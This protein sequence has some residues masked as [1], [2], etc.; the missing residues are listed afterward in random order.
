MSSEISSP[1]AAPL[2]SFRALLGGALRIYRTHFVALMG[3]A[4]WLALP[5][6]LHVV[7]RITF[8]DNDATDTALLVVSGAG[9]AIGTWS[10]CSI[11]R[12]AAH[13]HTTGHAP[14]QVPDVR[15]EL[16]PTFL[17]FAI[18]MLVVLVGFVAIL[19][20]IL[21]AVWF[22]FAPLITTLEKRNVFVALGESRML[23]R[24]RFFRILGRLFGMDLVF[25]FAYLVI[26]VVIDLALG[27]DFAHLDITAPLPVPMDIVLGTF[28]IVAV[29]IVTVFHTLLYLGAKN[30]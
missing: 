23:V 16:F 12:F 17:A 21:F 22:V 11:V 8:G 29:P 2:P 20:G 15:K 4:G 13:V 18:Y 25:L 9:F 30:R 7:L 10:Y 3:F 28:E 6:V 27:Y 26:V 1:H 14:D 5:L 19:P 24:G